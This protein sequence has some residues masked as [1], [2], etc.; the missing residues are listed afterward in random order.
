MRVGWDDKINLLQTEGIPV[1][2]EPQ[3]LQNQEENADLDEKINRLGWDSD[4]K[5]LQTNDEEYIE[6]LV[7]L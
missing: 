3:L 2:V 1:F 4:I 5:L 6:D 7:T